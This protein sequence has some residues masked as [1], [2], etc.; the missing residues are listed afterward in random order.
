MR[1]IALFCQRLSRE[2][3]PKPQAREFLVMVPQTHIAQQL[4]VN[5]TTVYR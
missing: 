5:R 4:A 3:V 2:L 1:I